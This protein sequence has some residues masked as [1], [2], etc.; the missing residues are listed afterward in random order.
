[1]GFFDIFRSGPSGPP[2]HA[3]AP[4]PP[5]ELALYKFDSCPY[6]IRVQRHVAKLGIDVPTRDIHRDPDARR[7]LR[8]YTGGGQVP[9]LFID[10]TPLLESADI[11]AWLTAYAEASESVA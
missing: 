4:T 2:A 8:E 10:G 9:C 3:P 11:N 7:E 5:R 6:C 1:M